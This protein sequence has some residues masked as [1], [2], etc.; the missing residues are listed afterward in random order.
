MSV[1]DYGSE[2]P[3]TKLPRFLQQDPP[4]AP[5]DAPPEEIR[6]LCS[7]YRLRVPFWTTFGYAIFYFVRKNLSTAM[8]VIEKEMG[9]TKASLG[10]FLTLHVVLYGISKFA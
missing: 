9:I 3:R 4:V 10:L 1:V 8:P 7:H 6:R 5:I 2:V